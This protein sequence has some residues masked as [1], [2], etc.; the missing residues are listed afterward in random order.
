MIYIPRADYLKKESY[1]IIQLSDLVAFGYLFG[2]AKKNESLN[3]EMSGLVEATYTEMIPYVKK[4]RRYMS[5]AMDRLEKANM[6]K[7]NHIQGEAIVYEL[8]P[9]SFYMLSDEEIKAVNAKYE[10]M[11]GGD[12]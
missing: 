10:K 6:I 8:L 9:I 4:S 11:M 3:S 2:K 7:R 5:T 1:K 12:Q